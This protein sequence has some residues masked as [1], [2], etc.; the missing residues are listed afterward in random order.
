MNRLT[1]IEAARVISVLQTTFDKIKTLLD[2]HL[3]L[4]PPDLTQ[5]FVPEQL[6]KELQNHKTLDET[7]L[8]L[9]EPSKDLNHST[10]V[11]K[12]RDNK[13]QIRETEENIKE[14]AIRLE[15]ML[16]QYPDAMN[17][18]LLPDHRSDS[19][20]KFIEMF[21]L[22]LQLSKVR[23]ETTVEEANEKSKR[24]E[25]LRHTE[26]NFIQ[27]KEKLLKDKEEEE[28]TS[29]KEIQ[30]LKDNEYRLAKTIQKIKQDNTAFA[31]KCNSDLE[32]MT[33]EFKRQHDQRMAELVAENEQLQKELEET[34]E[35]NRQAEHA[36]LEEKQRI[37]KEIE[38][39][40]SQYDEQ[41]TA[42][43]NATLSGQEQLDADAKRIQDLE[44]EIAELDRREKIDAFQ[45]ELDKKI[46]EEKA[47]EKM[48]RH[49]Q[50]SIIQAL[51]RRR[52]AMKIGESL[53][54]AAARKNKSKKKEK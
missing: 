17:K 14:S 9:I 15:R 29:G 3:E 50:V 35:A 16:H 22:L 45:A 39:K 6:L 1:Q 8:E 10:H 11:P 36:L 13:S 4:L 46:E 47:A 33:Q 32:T 27:Q 34:M 28:K 48:K 42:K 25:I 24:M 21:D 5:E 43:R 23:L 18:L 53:R 2:L 20:A 19:A 12:V 41:M 7:L 54:K 44:Q 26:R 30:A 52:Q 51:Y 49:R 40:I 38:T 37:C 31:A